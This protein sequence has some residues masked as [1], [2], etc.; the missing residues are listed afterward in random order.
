M[1]VKKIGPN[2]FWIDSYHEH[3]VHEMNKQLMNYV[4]IVQSH[5]ATHKEKKFQL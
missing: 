3:D 4:M 1:H 2:Y 5:I